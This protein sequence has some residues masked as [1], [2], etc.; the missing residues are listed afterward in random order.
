MTQIHIGA[1]NFGSTYGPFK[2]LQLQ[3]DIVR[4]ILE[5]ST[6]L[7]VSVIDTAADYGDAESLLGRIG[8][9]G[10]DINSKVAKAGN[11]GSP[12]KESIGNRILRSCENSLRELRK[13]SLNVLSIHDSRDLAAGSIDEAISTLGDLKKEGCIKK[14]GISVYYPTHIPAEH[15]PKIDYVQ[16]PGNLF[17]RR[18]LDNELLWQQLRAANIELSCRSIFMNGAVLAVG[19][20]LSLLDLPTLLREKI[21]MLNAVSP[22]VESRIKHALSAVL[23]EPCVPDSLVIGVNGEDHL[24]QI[25]QYCQE[26]RAYN[27]FADYPIFPSEDHNILIPSYWRCTRES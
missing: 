14:I 23:R 2:K 22:A 11:E 7:G 21:K 20:D 8:V 18:F 13:D 5:A 25:I 10:F 17:D 24:R 6:R 4:K 19:D 16:F 27:R 3:H 12:R 1:A 26:L 9:S 15:L